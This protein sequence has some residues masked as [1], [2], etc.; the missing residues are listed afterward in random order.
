M[1]KLNVA[2]LFLVHLFLA[3]TTLALNTSITFEGTLVDQYSNVVNLE[4]KNIVFVIYGV[5]SQC[6]FYAESSS[7]SGKTDGSILHKLGTGNALFGSSYSAA[8]FGSITTGFFIDGSACISAFPNEN[9]NLKVSVSDYGIELYV[10]LTS[11]PYALNT[12]TLSGKNLSSFILT[13]SVSDQVK[14]NTIMQNGSSGQVLSKNG[15]GNLEWINAGGNGA[16][17]GTVL[18]V[19]TSSPYLTITSSTTTPDISVNVGTSAGT[20]TAGDDPRLTDSRNPIGPAGGDLSGSYP[21]PSINKILGINLI[22]TP[23]SSGQVLRYNGSNWAPNFISMSDLRSKITGATSL[24]DTSCTASQTITFNSI[25]DTMACQPISILTNQVSGL[26]SLATMNDIDLTSAL[27]GGVLPISKGGTGSTSGSISV[28]NDP[29]IF[30][31]THQNIKLISSSTQMILSPN[32]LS[33]GGEPAN[34]SIFHIINNTASKYYLDDIVIESYTTLGS[35]ALKGAKASGSLTTPGFINT[36]D[37]IFSLIGSVYDGDGTG[38]TSFKDTAKISFIADGTQT[39]LSLP[40]RIDFFTTA[41]GSITNRPVVSIKSTGLEVSGTIK[42]HVFNGSTSTIN[43]AESSYQTTSLD[44]TAFVF[45]NLKSGTTYNLAI[46]GASGGTCS[47]L[48]YSD[49]GL[50]TITIKLANGIHLTQNAGDVL[51]Y[52]IVVMN[53][54]AYI[55]SEKYPP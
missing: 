5:Q 43:F 26:G 3:R 48:G 33:L 23:Q 19:S 38:H 30:N 27:V 37:S 22:G 35:G 50:S 14:F 4:N 54:V 28:D 7:I 15:D 44:C 2:L 29:L 16:S 1:K 53:N 11:V 45:H 8:L 36:N 13:S 20:L 17:S 6:Y 52:K 31:S 24:S 9:K 25:L 46:Q 51:L 21:N 40:S 39:S 32:G 18:S 42:M 55:S 47:F 41:S 34:S 12:E 49:T 10:E